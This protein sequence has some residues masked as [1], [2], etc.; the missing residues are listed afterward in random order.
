[1]NDD[2]GGHQGARGSLWGSA[3]R[4]PARYTDPDRFDVTRDPSGHV[5]FGV[6]IHLCLGRALGPA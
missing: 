2:P 6:G 4:D 1:M 3:D 5:A